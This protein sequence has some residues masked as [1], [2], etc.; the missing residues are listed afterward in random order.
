VTWRATASRPETA[1]APAA[2]IGSRAP[3]NI[4]VTGPSAASTAIICTCTQ[5]RKRLRTKAES[6]QN[7]QERPTPMSDPQSLRLYATQ[8]H[9][10]GM[11]SSLMRY[12]AVF[13]SQSVRSRRVIPLSAALCRREGP[14][15]RYVTVRRAGWPAH[16]RTPRTAP[17]PLWPSRASARPCLS[18]ANPRSLPAEPCIAQARLA[19]QPFFYLQVFICWHSSIRGILSC[20][21]KMTMCSLLFASSLQVRPSS[22]L[23]HP[24]QLKTLCRLL[25]AS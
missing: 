22:S 12:Q 2:A 1:V 13:S 11:Q 20:I 16:G 14:L 6:A 7:T 10:R 17:P 4:T 23:K 9:E 18:C 19:L 3:E 8:Y 15:Q 24:V 21:L 25:F 5:H